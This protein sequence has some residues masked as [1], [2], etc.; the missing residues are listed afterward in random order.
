MRCLVC[1]ETLE[2]DR[3][4]EHIRAVHLSPLGLT[5]EMILEHARK[6]A[7][8]LQI[9]TAYLTCINL[10]EKV[11]YFSLDNAELLIAFAAAHRAIPWTDIVE[12]Q[13]LHEK[14][15][16]ACLGQYEP[17][18]P[19]RPMVLI[20]AEDYYINRYL[21]PE[22]YWPVCLMNARCAT[23]IRNLAPLPHNLRDPYYYCTLATF[24]AYEAVTFG[25]IH[26]LTSRE[27]RLV[28]TISAIFKQIKE[29]KDI[30]GASQEISQV[31]DRIQSPGGARL[32][33]QRKRDLPPGH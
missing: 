1:G 29:V 14:G 20:N 24:I 22:T 21:I 9:K 13:I 18:Y 28:N 26:F 33:L 27:A 6:T 3:A 16:L 31:F 12:W 5:Q 30:P 25:D 11:I 7:H 17:L 10:Q 19:V 8:P 23:A 2:K 32:H 15:H 4:W